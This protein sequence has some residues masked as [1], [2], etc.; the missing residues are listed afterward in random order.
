MSYLLYRECQPTSNIGL[1][2]FFRPTSGSSSDF[3]G[4]EY[5]FTASISVINIYR[6][7]R[8][9]S[10][11]GAY[12]K[13]V[14]H[15]GLFGRI[16]DA[17]VFTHTL[18]GRD[19]I[20][21]QLLL[22]SIDEGKFVLARFD[23]SNF[24]F[25]V[26]NM[27]N[28]EENA[29]G[30]GTMVRGDMHGRNT[31]PGIG[32]VPYL[33]ID[34]ANRLGCAVLYS[35]QLF[36]MPLA[37]PTTVLP[38]INSDALVNLKDGESSPAGT[39]ESALFSQFLID[40]YA[41][42]SL[43][44]VIL[45]V[46]FLTGLPMPTIAIL[47]ES[48]ILAVGHCAA[49]LHTCAVTVMAADLVKKSVSVIWQ[50]MQLPHD[51]I[52]LLSTPKSVLGSNCGVIVVSMNAL[53]VVTQEA[54]VGL[55][56]NGFAG[57]TVSSHISLQ[58]WEFDE[59]L[60]LDSSHWAE[61]SD[62]AVM[63]SLKTGLL[64]S[65]QL[66][67]IE[68]RS[69]LLAKFKFVVDLVAVSVRASSLSVSSLQDMWFLGNRLSEAVLLHVHSVV[70]PIQISSNNPDNDNAS[71]KAIEPPTKRAKKSTN[72]SQSSANTP[73]R[74]SSEEET[75]LYGTQLCKL[76][77]SGDIARVER[78]RIQVADG[79]KVMG[80]ILDAC[81][82]RFDDTFN[83]SG[84]SLDWSRVGKPKGK[85]APGAAAS[86]IAEREIK[87]YLQLCAG[88]D[89]QG[90]VHR[91]SR[92]VRLSKLAA[93]NFAQGQSVNFLA[94]DSL[95]VSLLF[96]STAKR[97]RLFLCSEEVTGVATA[98]GAGTVNSVCES[99]LALK[100]TVDSGFIA[101]DNTIATGCVAS[102]IA[103][104]VVSSGVRLAKIDPQTGQSDPLQ[105]VQ[106]I[107]SIE[108]GGLGGSETERIVSGDVCLGF[109]AVVSSTNAVYVLEY[110]PEDETLIL[111]HSPYRGVMEIDGAGTPG[112]LEKLLRS[113][114]A[115]A[116]FF[117]GTF[118]TMQQTAASTEAG[119]GNK[120][121]L[122]V[123]TQVI[124][125]KQLSA[126]VEVEELYM[127]GQKLC[128]EVH[129]HM[130]VDAPVPV[131]A[132]P[133]KGKGRG[134]ITNIAPKLVTDENVAVPNDTPQG[135]FIGVHVLVWDI[136]GY[137]Q[138][139]ALES[140]R[141]VMATDRIPLM[142]EDFCSLTTNP[143]V[144]KNRLIKDVRLAV[145]GRSAS[146]ESTHTL[147]LVAMLGT[148]DTI[149]YRHNGSMQQGRF[150]K[151]HHSCV[152]RRRRN[153]LKTRELKKDSFVLL[154][155]D[156]ASCKLSF[157]SRLDGQSCI[158]ISGSCPAI[159]SNQFG[160][161]SVLPLSFPEVPYANAGAT[162][163]C[164]FSCGNIRG[165]GALW[166]EHDDGNESSKANKQSSLEIY[167]ENAG[168]YSLSG[169]CISG[170]RLMVGKTVHFSAEFSRRSD[171]KTEQELLERKT[172]VLACSEE[173]KQ[174]FTNL[175]MTHAEKEADLAL[176]DRYIPL[177]ESF[178]EPDL[179]L[180]PAPPLSDR[181]FSLV[182][183]QGGEAVASYSLP[184]HEHIL[185][186]EA[187]WLIVEKGTPQIGATKARP[188][189]RRVFVVVSTVIEQEHGEDT[190]GEGR[191]LLFAIDYAYFQDDSSAGEMNNE[192]EN[193]QDGAAKKEEKLVSSAEQ[194]AKQSAFFGAIQP[195]LKQ[196]WAGPGPAS[197]VKQIGEYIV[198]TVGCSL[199]VYK[200]L[201]ESLELEQV[202]FYYA[203]F[204]I[205]SISIIKD[206]F[207]MITDAHK[208]VAFLS[209]KED[210]FA[211]IL[212][213]KDYNDCF[214][215]STAFVADGPAL[216]MMV[217]DD[218]GNVQLLQYAPRWVIQFVHYRLKCTTH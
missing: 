172:F 123:I 108:V 120:A 193:G 27:F 105:D 198:T 110:L 175:V 128:N 35:S 130:E 63:G 66:V 28:A 15:S 131:A 14:F 203:T 10:D 16:Q 7:F 164:P 122:P 109:V 117:V 104:Q 73:P 33:T 133:I 212:L 189:K 32:S 36:F 19:Q 204:Y 75:L 216:G 93:R 160:L 26:I 77:S 17:Q 197:C 173:T 215:L 25:N 138:I 86:Y 60:E 24:S 76:L 20:T 39:G 68:N 137:L 129:V 116:S 5:L 12:L 81:F 158:L 51:S 142:S 65:V 191:L 13:Q 163:M 34:S 30:T 177:M 80:P 178:C 153:K 94:D 46:Q 97:T 154:S 218:E 69:S 56:F 187:V 96:L 90:A 213:G 48:S 54:V 199:Y 98:D 134:K 118:P 167:Q 186:M 79:I 23:T 49:V 18:V 107:E 103:V 181:L 83:T 143:G 168:C 180:G 183:T 182:L 195:K 125:E 121:Q 8:S 148:G 194:T 1:S 196:I 211:L 144:E 4:D 119:T 149:C 112:Q 151:V 67:G 95:R 205:K 184:E 72:D 47:Q 111:K 157:V 210:D 99:H 141:V 42:L 70:R 147:C 176:H 22:L 135:P 43:P 170:K 50:Q 169:G 127:Y 82:C 3:P 165:I 40:M 45:D 31:F 185:G 74:T 132:A 155:D 38:S 209:W 207:I 113:P 58:P 208:S 188:P 61:T 106:I 37:L 91:I 152:T 78:Y 9:P 21:E 44:G 85:I 179:D 156:I 57:T 64:V 145:L 11:K 162:V 161:P 166:T 53:L 140:L 214:G 159:V 41:S 190:Q 124:D 102:G 126:R 88:L 29:V 200:L 55:A 89:N 92:G 84:T 101:V 62:N 6:V 146:P 52:R 2:Q 201:P 150:I 115:G 71:T 171:D 217:G 139:I 136:H 100:E 114:A 192:T 202:A 206:S 174:P 59:G 87:D